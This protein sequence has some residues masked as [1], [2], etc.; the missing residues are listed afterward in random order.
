PIANGAVLGGH[1]VANVIK[2]LLPIAIMSVAGYAVGWRINGPLVD[3]LHAYV[4]MI[5]FAFAMIWIGVLMGSLVSTPEGVTGFAFAV[6]FP[7]TFIAST[8]VPVASMPEPLQ[9]VA[10]WNPTTTLSDALRELFANP[11][12]PVQPGD[13]WPI[14]HPIAY[15]WLWIV[16][17]VVVIAPL[18]VAV[19]RRSNAD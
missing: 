15:T 2:A 18:A 6:L 1:A 13:P 9:T 5:A 12:T 16:G 14:V 7:I 19:Y 11:N 3:T 17:L 10:Q 8:F 4:L